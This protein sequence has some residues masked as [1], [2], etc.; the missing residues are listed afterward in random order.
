[1]IGA[2]A[3]GWIQVAHPA[4]SP[5]LR[6]FC[7]AHAGGG[8][9]LFRTWHEELPGTVEV[10]GIQLPGRESRWKEPPIPDLRRV[11]DQLIPAL[12]SRLHIPFAIYGHSMGALLAFELARELRRRGLPAPLAL[13]VSG[14]QA[15]YLSDGRREIATLSDA[16]FLDRI[17]KRYQAIPQVVLD[18]PELLRIFLPTLRADFTLIETYRYV[19]E[20]A[21]SCPVSV[22]QGR[23][24]V[25]VSFDQLAGW[26]TLT[27]GDF[28]IELLPGGHFFLQTDRLPLL[29]RISRELDLLM[30]GRVT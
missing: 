25:T 9:A 19:E 15:P 30:A 1:M 17:C 13:L 4:E 7:L 20:P 16:E 5:R 12:Q 11:L 14:R 10:C 2:A 23:D 22:Y 18:E 28:K 3:N 27:S 6:L 26:R 21:L 8:A 29:R 24:D